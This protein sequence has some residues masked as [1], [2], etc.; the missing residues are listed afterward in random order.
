MENSKLIALLKTF[1]TQELRAFKDFVASPYF[2]K[3]QELVLFYDYL[4]KIAP[5][6]PLK[7]IS[8][9]SIYNNLFPKK[10]YDDKHMNYLMSFTYF[11][12]GKL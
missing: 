11:N 5:K 9:E 6:F 12:S 1:N 3:N 2:N 10:E 8:R 4:K 7:K